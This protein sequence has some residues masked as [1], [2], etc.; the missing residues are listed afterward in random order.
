MA[1]HDLNL[2]HSIQKHKSRAQ[3]PEG[4]AG[5]R[6]PSTVSDTPYALVR[7]I[8]SLCDL[9]YPP[10]L[11]YPLPASGSMYPGARD[12]YPLLDWQEGGDPMVTHGSSDAPRRRRTLTSAG[13][14]S[15]S[16]RARSRS[17]G[18]SAAAG[19][20]LRA[21][22]GAGRKRDFGRARVEL[23]WVHA[24][25]PAPERGG[26]PLL[27]RLGPVVRLAEHGHKHKGHGDCTPFMGACGCTPIPEVYPPPQ[28]VP[29][30]LEQEH[31]RLH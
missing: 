13:A 1:C 16:S 31:H 22:G 5:H 7:Y 14:T 28:V 15:S 17:T 24:L 20:P 29:P 25:Q 11:S 18:K 19:S 21:P 6:P 12:L 3:R 10:C 27:G 23:R 9:M 2:S 8:P 30:P 4:G 26:S